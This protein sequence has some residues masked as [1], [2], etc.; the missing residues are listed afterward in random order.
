MEE[1]YE[2]IIRDKET[3]YAFVIPALRTIRRIFNCGLTEAKERLASSDPIWVGTLQECM[4]KRVLF[5]M[6]KVPV[7]IQPRET[8]IRK[9]VMYL[10][11]EISL[12]EKLKATL[13][14]EEY[15][16][17]LQTLK[18]VLAKVEAFHRAEY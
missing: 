1:D 5:E 10:K 11:A 16:V 15:R 9:T 6:E 8:A 4:A 3:P 13:S 12:T 2:L 7:K 18:T 14:E 17:I